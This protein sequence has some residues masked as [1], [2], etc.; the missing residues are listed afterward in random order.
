MG[1][2]SR[3]TCSYA[4]VVHTALEHDETHLSLLK[5]F[6]EDAAATVK[7]CPLRGDPLWYEWEP[8]ETF[9]LILID[10]ELPDQPPA[11]HT[12]PA[13]DHLASREHQ[14]TTLD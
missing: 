3:H 14:V 10:P 6:D 9:D 7:L 2:D 8:T 12:Q 13:E 11:V 1:A 5:A 4:E